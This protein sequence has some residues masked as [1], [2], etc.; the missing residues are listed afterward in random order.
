METHTW[1]RFFRRINHLLNL[2]YR[3]RSTLTRGTM[4]NRCLISPTSYYIWPLNGTS[5]S[6]SRPLSLKEKDTPQQNPDSL[7]QTEEPQLEE[8]RFYRCKKCNVAVAK[9]G[10]ECSIGRQ[11]S[12][13][14]Q[15]NPHGYVHGVLTV[16][17]AFNIL[18]YGDPVA[19]DSWFPGYFWRFCLC[20]QC[21]SHLGWSYHLPGEHTYQFIGLRRESVLKD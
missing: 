19:A 1:N 4:E 10:S 6:L 5:W 18:L 21:A 20:V 15:V 2:F 8:D 7:A 3:N 17:S 11:K 9:Q 16:R 14:L 12:H 13:T